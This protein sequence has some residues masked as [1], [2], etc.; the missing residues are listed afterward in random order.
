MELDAGCG[1]APGGPDALN[2]GINWQTSAF[3]KKHDTFV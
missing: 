2:R 3:P 1:M